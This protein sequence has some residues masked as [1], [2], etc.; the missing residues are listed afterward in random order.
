MSHR[1]TKTTASAAVSIRAGLL[2]DINKQDVISN[3][4]DKSLGDAKIL[5]TNLPQVG[6]TDNYVLSTIPSCHYC[7][8]DCQTYLVTITTHN[9]YAE[10]SL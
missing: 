1:K 8:R 2:P 5:W 10:T 6:K 3:I 7:F 9:F 4:Q